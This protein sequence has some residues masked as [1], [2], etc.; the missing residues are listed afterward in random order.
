MKISSSRW[1]IT[2]GAALIALSVFFYILHYAIFKDPHHIFSY[3]LTD[4]A[5][6]P[7]EV[8]LVTLIIHRLLTMRE[9]RER[10]EKINMVIGV[11]FSEL[12]TDLLSE[13][14]GY[15][16]KLDEI[17]KE[18]VIS[19]KETGRG[20]STMTKSL[21]GHEYLVDIRRMD[22]E[23]LRAR[24]L[25]KRDLLLRL[26]ENPILLEHELFTDLL[27]AVHHLTEELTHRKD[28]GA[29]PEPDLNH[30]RGDIKRAYATLVVTWLAYMK[31]LSES[32]PYLFSLA[33]RVNPFDKNASPVVS[34][35]G[36][37]GGPVF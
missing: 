32:Y 1:Q 19:P 12:G 30:L 21:K 15:D 25:G 27:W 36:Q 4:L 5:F 10:L 22:L 8:L 24:L 7:I 9:T 2:A 16:P 31:H 23:E 18:L 14:S 28:F 26:L 20:Y 11:F 35:P 3:L 6:L 34:E 37:T 13:F 29:L 17:R 33:I